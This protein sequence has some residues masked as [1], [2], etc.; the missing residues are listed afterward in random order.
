MEG[1]SWWTQFGEKE[2]RGGFHFTQ[3]LLADKHT[4]HWLCL[5]LSPII[6]ETW[7]LGHGVPTHH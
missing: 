2:V 3:F 5:L 1:G 7:L 4:P 6:V